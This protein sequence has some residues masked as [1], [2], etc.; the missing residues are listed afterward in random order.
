MLQVG[1]VLIGLLELPGWLGKMLVAL[2]LIG[3]PIALI[4]AWI[5]D[6]TPR[7]I[8]VTG[9]ESA[10]SDDA[11]TFSEPEPIDVGEL[12]LVAPEIGELIGRDDECSTLRTC[13]QAAKEGTG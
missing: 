8:V 3:L 5:Y 2:V 4:V 12:Q 11:F 9:D 13:L 6:W 7:G 10:A 1:D